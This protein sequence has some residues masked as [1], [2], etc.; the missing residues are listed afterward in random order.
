LAINGGDFAAIAGDARI[1]GAPGAAGDFALVACICSIGNFAIFRREGGPFGGLFEPARASAFGGESRALHLQI[2]HL[3]EQRLLLRDQFRRAEFDKNL[4]A[5]YARPF[6]DAKTGNDSA[7]AVLHRL[8]VAG[9][10]HD[11]RRDH[12]RVQRRERR[13]AAETG[14]EHDQRRNPVADFRGA[15]ILARFIA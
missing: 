9:D 8:P 10:D 5:L 3:R 2:D 4:A 13:P 1:E 15:G 14:K 7:F 12:S 11:A 6:L